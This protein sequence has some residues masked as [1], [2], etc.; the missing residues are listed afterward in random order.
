MHFFL[1]SSV[2][3]LIHPPTRL[4]VH[5]PIHTPIHPSIH[6]S[7][8]APPHPPITPLPIHTLILIHPSRSSIHLPI[9]PLTNPH[10]P[11]MNPFTYPFIVR[12]CV[13]P[14][15]HSSIYPFTHSSTHPSILQL[16]CPTTPLSN[17][18]APPRCLH[19]K[20]RYA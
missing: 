4:S 7:T 15:L 5:L 12:S 14:L 13:Q 16:V 2:C 19:S 20:E 10:H 17:S 11:S 9:H 8:H 1:C 3:L 6:L 18:A